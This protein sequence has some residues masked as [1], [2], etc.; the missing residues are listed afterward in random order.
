MAKHLKRPGRYWVVD[1][2]WAR[3]HEAMLGRLRRNTAW[4][5]TATHG[6]LFERLSGGFL[7]PLCA[8]PH[9]WRVR[10]HRSSDGA[11]RE[12]FP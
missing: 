2:E 6:C 11:F 10:N 3:R 9:C 12:A 5:D 8:S 7:V 1:L 4:L